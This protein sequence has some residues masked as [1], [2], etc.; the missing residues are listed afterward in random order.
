MVLAPRHLVGVLVQVLVRDVMVL[1]RDGAAQARE[2]AFGLMVQAPFAEKASEWLIRWASY[3][4]S[5]P[6]QCGTP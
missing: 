2:L 5:S 3:R 4:N 6:S 1:T